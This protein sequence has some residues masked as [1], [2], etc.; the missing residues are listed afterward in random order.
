[1][2]ATYKEI[3]VACDVWVYARVG[4]RSYWFSGGVVIFWVM[5]LRLCVNLF[6]SEFCFFICFLNVFL[7]FL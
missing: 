2:V 7:L 4:G 1:V 3:A 6:L 5:L